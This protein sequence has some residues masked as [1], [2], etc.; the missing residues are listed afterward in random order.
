M[1]LKKDHLITVLPYLGREFKISFEVYLSS[2]ASVDW[3]NVIHFTTGGNDR[4][5]GYRIPAIFVTKYNQFHIIC[6]LNGITNKQFVTKPQPLK[7]WIPLIITQKPSN[8][9]VNLHVGV[10]D[11]LLNH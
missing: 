1:V 10:K 3:V 5:Y 7:K 11:T 2:F 8:G 6:S 4:N 9:K